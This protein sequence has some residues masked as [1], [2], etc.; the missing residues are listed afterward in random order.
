MM[1]FYDD[2]ITV[3]VSRGAV[4]QAPGGHAGAATPGRQILAPGTEIEPV[5]TG[6]ITTLTHARLASRTGALARLRR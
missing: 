2:G 1:L 6:V 5:V 4:K 3:K